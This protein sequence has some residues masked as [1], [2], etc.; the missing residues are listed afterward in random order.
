MTTIEVLNELHSRSK[1]YIGIMPK[2]TYSMTIKRMREY[3]QNHTPI[4]EKY[5]KRRENT[6][7]SFFNRLGYEG[8][9]NTW[10]KIQ[11]TTPEKVIIK[12]D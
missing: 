9:Y 7:R 3:E 2:C 8:Q 6:K 4:K 5:L 11:A 1:G 10:N 12:I